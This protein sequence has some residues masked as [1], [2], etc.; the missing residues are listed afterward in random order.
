MST[1][2]ILSITCDECKKTVS[3][4]FRNFTCQHTGIMRD[5][6]RKKGWKVDLA[7]GGVSSASLVGPDYCADCRPDHNGNTDPIPGLDS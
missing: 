5:A 7:G 4:S 2:I 3:H 1:N 6:A